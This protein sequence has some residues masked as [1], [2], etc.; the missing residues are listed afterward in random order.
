MRTSNSRDAT[1]GQHL[2]PLRLKSGQEHARFLRDM[3]GWRWKPSV[4]LWTVRNSWW[5]WAVA[6]SSAVT[7]AIALLSDLKGLTN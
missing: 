6:A 2:E 4:V 5:P 3:Q 7:A 1:P